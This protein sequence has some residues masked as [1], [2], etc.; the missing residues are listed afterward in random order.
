MSG[1]LEIAQKLIQKKSVT[2]IDDGAID[3]LRDYLEDIGFE[4]ESLEF[5]S[6]DSYPVKNLYAKYGKASPNFCFA[7]HTDV[8]PAGDEKAWSEPPF[9]AK[10]VNGELIG[11]GAV[12]MK[13]AIAS[14]VYAAEKF[15]KEKF[16]GS[17]SLLITGDEEADAI[18]GTVKLL[19]YISQNGDKIDACI[20]GEPT[21]PEVLGEMVKIGRRGSMNVYIEVE[22]VQ[23]HSAYP[24]LADNPIHKLTKILSEIQDLTLDDGNEY[25][26][27]SNIQVVNIDVGNKAT[28]VIPAKARAVLNIR[29]NDISTPEQIRDKIELL[30]I[31]H[32]G[33]RYTLKSVVGAETFITKSGELSDILVKSIRDI[34]KLEPDLSTAGGTSDAR[35]VKDYCPVVEFGLINKTAHKVD[36]KI[37]VVDLE[38]LSE[39]YYNTLQYYFKKK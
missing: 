8:V 39:I 14:F 12:D 19:Q 22:G 9:A 20:V 6:D 33:N 7:G 1:V 4:C 10:V 13:G 37:S 18:N 25:F 30:V 5:E 21:N 11:R 35:Y 23:G 2:P 26:Q 17:I 34:T 15:I 16:E 38:R 28:N 24:N 29:F 31:S 36:E 32:V 3:Y 27:P